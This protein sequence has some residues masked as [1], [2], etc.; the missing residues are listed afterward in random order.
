MGKCIVERDFL[1][2]LKQHFAFINRQ[3]EAYKRDEKW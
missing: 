1:A 2:S 3:I